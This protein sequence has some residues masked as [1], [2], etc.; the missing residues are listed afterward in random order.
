M[1]PEMSQAL[2]PPPPLAELE[3]PALFLDLDGTLAA[4]E[5]RPEDVRPEPWR[6]RLILDLRDRLDG[7]LAVVSGRTLEDVDRI[8]EGAAP[9]LSVAVRRRLASH[10]YSAAWAALPV[11]SLLGHDFALARAL[12][13]ATPTPGVVFQGSADAET[14]LEALRAAPGLGRVRIVVVPEGTHSNTYEL[15]KDRIVATA[16]AMLRQPRR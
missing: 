8:L 11:A 16:V 4:I 15:A 13:A 10:G 2:P 14:P 5:P 3:R 12:S 6:T 9:S 7:R 1:T